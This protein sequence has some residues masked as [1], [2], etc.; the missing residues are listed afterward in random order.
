MH[1]HITNML[2]A[3]LKYFDINIDLFYIYIYNYLYVC[4]IFAH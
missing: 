1:A 4:S 2:N 3:L